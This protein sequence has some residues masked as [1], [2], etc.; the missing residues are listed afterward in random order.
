MPRKPDIEPFP[1]AGG[2]YLL[3]E[4]SGKWILQEPADHLNSDDGTDTSSPAA[5]EG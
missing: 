5:G 2:T 1:S 3:D 4:G